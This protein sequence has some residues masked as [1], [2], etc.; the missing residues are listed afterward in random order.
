MRDEIEL[1]PY[2]RQ[3]TAV[4]H[5]ALDRQPALRQL[6]K[7]LSLTEYASILARLG[8]AF[9]ESEKYLE[10]ASLPV[11]MP[12]GESRARASEADLEKLPAVELAGRQVLVLGTKSPWAATGVRYV[13]DGSSQGSRFIAGRLQ[14]NLP[15]LA[16][17]GAVEYWRAQE[18]VAS[19]W[20]TFCC[21]IGGTVS[22][23]DAEDALCGARATFSLF[24]ACFDASNE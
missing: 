5:R 12:D 8:V 17:L 13:L 20:N 4:D 15:E 23:A 9:R 21:S 11:V 22:P 10:G 3:H 16:E 24:Q 19:H 7:D 1:L 14:N 2:L 18:R 6:M